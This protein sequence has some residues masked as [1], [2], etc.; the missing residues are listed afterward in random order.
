MPNRLFVRAKVRVPDQPSIRLKQTQVFH[1]T[2]DNRSVIPYQAD[3]MDRFVFDPSMNNML[4][5]LLADGEVGLFSNDDFKRLNLSQIKSEGE[6]A[7]EFEP[8]GQK[9]ASAAD[10][11]MTIGI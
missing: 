1:I 8:T 4:V 10:L 2:G 5:V 6:H 3:R 11:R 7:F 9:V